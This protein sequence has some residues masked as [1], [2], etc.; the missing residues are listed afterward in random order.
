[1]CWHKWGKWETYGQK[2]TYH[3]FE[4]DKTIHYVETQQKRTCEKCGLEQQR[5]VKEQ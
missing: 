4:I 3:R 5:K 2:M 1:M